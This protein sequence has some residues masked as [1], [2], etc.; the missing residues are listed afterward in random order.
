MAVVPRVVT[1]TEHTD[2]RM[3]CGLNFPPFWLPQRTIFPNN[4][5]GLVE[6]GWV[7]HIAR[8]CKDIKAYTITCR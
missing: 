7:V 5:G 8:I 3:L 4:L 2:G 1:G 6:P